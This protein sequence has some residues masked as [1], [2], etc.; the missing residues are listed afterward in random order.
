[1][2]SDLESD[3]PGKRRAAIEHILRHRDI[4]HDDIKSIAEKYIAQNRKGGTVRDALHL[5][6]KLHARELIPYLVSRLN[7]AVSEQEVTAPPG[8][9]TVYPAAGALIYIGLPSIKPVLARLRTGGDSDALI[10][11]AGV[12][13]FILG[14]N[15]A[16]KRIAEE[17][18]T[19]TAEE[20]TE[21][22]QVKEY[23]TNYFMLQ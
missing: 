13:R 21:L 7:Y 2:L 8:I 23:L 16:L 3:D 18:S 22:G 1:M 11:G 15:G 19:A 17:M 14:K 6:G 4:A 12:L 20:R 9:H 5:L 10:A